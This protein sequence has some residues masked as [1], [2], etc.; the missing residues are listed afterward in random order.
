MKTVS[1]PKVKKAW[2][3][4]GYFSGTLFDIESILIGGGVF[5]STLL[6]QY[7][8]AMEYENLTV[9]SIPLM[10]SAIDGLT[11]FIIGWHLFFLILAAYTR[12]LS[13]F[14]KRR[15]ILSFFSNTI[16]LAV[17]AVLWTHL[18]KSD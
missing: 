7:N 8:V 17:N 1:D 18:G 14:A 9:D 3:I 13:H 11:A 6:Y 15:K 2:K 16:F 12:I 4:L 5:V 10:L